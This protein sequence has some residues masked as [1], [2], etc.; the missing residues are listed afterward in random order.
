MNIIRLEEAFITTDSR[1]DVN[2]L[3]SLAIIL[4]YAENGSLEGYVKAY[5]DK[6]VPENEVLLIM[7]QVCLGLH[8]LYNK[9]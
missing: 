6:D 9:E 1:A 2:V 3:G 7:V 5:G 8:F 4:D